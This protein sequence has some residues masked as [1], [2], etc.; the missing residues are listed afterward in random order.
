ME[1]PH[2]SET[3]I[4]P[5]WTIFEHILQKE[6]TKKIISRKTLLDLNGQL[7][8]ELRMNDNELTEMLNFL[9]RV[10]SLLYFD[11]GNLK[12]TIILDLSWF[13]NAFK[14]LLKYHVSLS[15][16]C[17]SKRNR[18]YLTGELDDQELNEIWGQ[19]PDSAE[20]FLHKMEILS[21]MEQLGLLAICNSGNQASKENAGVWYYIP[22][23]NN[24]EF[25]MDNKKFTTSSILCFEFDKDGQLPTYLFHGVILKCLKIPRWSFLLEDDRNCIYKNVACFSF[26]D[27]IVVICLCKF[28]IQ[29]QVWVPQK[30]YEYIDSKLLEEIQ[31]SVEDKIR[32][33]KKYSYTV[34]YKCQNGVLNNE[35]DNLFVAKEEF[36]VFNLIC[37][38]CKLKN[39]HNVDNSI[40]WV[41]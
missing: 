13:V 35:N 29:V 8:M 4:R 14:C 2:Y 31:Q 6:K 32:E 12:E 21:Y 18:F 38:R 24:R 34:G 27:H 1:D 22:S 15:K 10:G 33:Y 7:C 37:K 17:D 5:L 30:K 23:M 3:L 39:K 20:Y 28:Q 9:H 36:P 11:E 25:D 16:A 41:C 19:C 40:C 26:R